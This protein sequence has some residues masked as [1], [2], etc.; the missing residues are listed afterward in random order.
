MCLGNVL[1]RCWKFY[2][3][4]LCLNSHFL[5][6]VPMIIHELMHA[7]SGLHEHQR[8]DRDFY[9][10]IDENHMAPS[11]KGDFAK[12]PEEGYVFSF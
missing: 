12:V 11:R 4:T 6:D 2:L 5:Q 10:Y 8:S 1:V 9:V 3:S 7:M